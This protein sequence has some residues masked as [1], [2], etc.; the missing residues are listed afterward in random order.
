MLPNKFR[1]KNRFSIM[2]NSLY[3]ILMFLLSAPVLGQKASI[4]F[5]K[6]VLQAKV[7]ET[8]K[9][10]VIF[11]TGDEPIAAFDIHLR[12]DPDLLKVVSIKTLQ[13]DLFSYHRPFRFD[14][15]KG[16]IDAS[17]YQ[18][19]KSVPTT[20]FGVAEITFVAIAATEKTTVEHVL[21]DF[22][23]TILAYGGVNMLKRVSNLEISISG[24]SLS[25]NLDSKESDLGLEIWPNP[26]SVSSLIKF[27]LPQTN[28]VYLGIFDLKGNLLSKVYEGKA[29]SETPYQF[30]FNVEHLAN[31]PYACRLVSGEWHQTEILIV[32]R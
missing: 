18:I 17:A 11:K 25:D 22:P 27:K 6:D 21:D 12:F 13:G 15:T 1:F 29:T 10:Q 8:F 5:D 19:D 4:V 7:G 24:E 9:T 3:I 14:N 23:K 31:G 32:A 30:E 26:S 2:K 16:K 28:R 20:D